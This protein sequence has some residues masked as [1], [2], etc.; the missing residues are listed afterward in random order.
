M[1]TTQK[2][3]TVQPVTAGA[4]NKVSGQFEFMF[5]TDFITFLLYY[6]NSGQSRDLYTSP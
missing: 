4:C 2:H 1:T 5:M 3:H 6:Y